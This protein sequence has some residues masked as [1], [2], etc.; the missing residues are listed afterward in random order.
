MG[1]GE[2][3]GRGRKLEREETALRRKKRRKEVKEKERVGRRKK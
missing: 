3:D 1:K 2:T